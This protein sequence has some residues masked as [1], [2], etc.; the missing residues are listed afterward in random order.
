VTSEDHG[1]VGRDTELAALEE[2]LSAA[3]PG[4]VLLVGAARTGKGR[5]LRELRR[6]AAAYPCKLV[7]A[8]EDSLTADTPG[9]VVDKETRI[10]D[11]RLAVQPPRGPDVGA[12][13][14]MRRD[15][16]VV[17]VYGY[18]PEEDFHQWF[19]SDFIPTLGKATPPR[20]L[21]V[22]ADANDLEEL[23]P[24]ANGEIALGPLPREDVM[25][26][27]RAIAATVADPPGEAELAVY[28]DAAVEDPSLLRALRHVLPLTPTADR[29]DSAQTE[30]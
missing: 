2:A 9:M 28:A 30:T 8:E 29:G 6:R 7:P 1:I 19:T 15:F 27:L 4:L 14:E 16:D 18:R 23:R 3:R 24:L 22:A 21:L 20:V 17:L 26:E 5:V 12:E 10:D 13:P 11:F 25:T